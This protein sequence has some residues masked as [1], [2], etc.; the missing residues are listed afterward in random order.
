MQPIRRPVAVVPMPSAQ[1][2]IPAEPPPAV[3]LAV[4]VAL[5]DMGE[6]LARFR[7]LPSKILLPVPSTPRYLPSSGN[8][9][10]ASCI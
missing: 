6:D 3:E 7:N 4:P 8:G 10:R 5:P 1:P 2:E 9:W